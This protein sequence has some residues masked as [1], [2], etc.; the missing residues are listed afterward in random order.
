MLLS[1][2]SGHATDTLSNET[3]QL[4]SKDPAIARIECA[5]DMWLIFLRRQW[6]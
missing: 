2:G 3:V 4:Y 6:S 5:D 1:L